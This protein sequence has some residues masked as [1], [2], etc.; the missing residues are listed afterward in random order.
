M[1]PV[2]FSNYDR[3]YFQQEHSFNNYHSHWTISFVQE[4]GTYDNYLVL[5][6]SNLHQVHMDYE[7]VVG[8]LHEM[9]SPQ[10]EVRDYLNSK[11]LVRTSSI[12]IYD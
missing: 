10:D 7:K 5:I 9:Q 2:I 6:S 4:V 8:T 12:W 1:V 3:I 11:S